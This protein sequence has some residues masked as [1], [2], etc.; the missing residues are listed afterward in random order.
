MKQ[1]SIIVLAI[2]LL[3]T[4]CAGS[5]QKISPTANV[6]LRTANMERNQGNIEVALKN[7]E[8]VLAERPDHAEALNNSGRIYYKNAS[9][10]PDIALENYTRAFNNFTAAIAQ[11]NSFDPV[12]EADKKE[13]K[14]LT[15]LRTSAWTRIFQMGAKEQ[16][17]GNT[18][19]AI[20]IFELAMQLDPKRD[21]P[22]RKLYE[23]YKDDASNPEKAEEILTQIFEQA[24]DDIT[25]V[26]SMGAFYFN[27]RQDYAKAMEFFE[28]VKEKEPLDT[29]NLLLLTVCQYEL[30]LYDEALENIQMVLSLEP[31]NTDALA[32][33]N[34]IAY[35]KGDKE[36][37]L[38]YMKRLL[39]LK[40]GEDELRSI[41][42]LLYELKQYEELVVYAE[43]WHDFSPEDQE[44]LLLIINAAKELKNKTLEKKY[45]DIFKKLQ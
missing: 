14:Q 3:L 38:Q 26:K 32:D 6:A 44:P 15:D 16:E 7:Y 43:K 36:L 19:E 12:T 45:T 9:D 23:I 28:I 33:A 5:R 25:V 39:T 18:K 35:Q 4:A 13:I 17:E 1:L 21:E 22:L 34:S 41:S 11:Y 30:H 31:N 27:D 37:S 2:A 24:S 42:Y 8:I 40:E 29:N 10:F 20:E